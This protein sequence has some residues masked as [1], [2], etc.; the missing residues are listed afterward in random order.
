M[1]SLF[2]VLQDRT[3]QIKKPRH[4]K[5]AMVDEIIKI[6]GVSAKYGYTY[7][8]RKIKDWSY[9]ELMGLLK[10]IEKMDSKYP[11]GATLTNKLLRK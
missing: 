8:L 4:E 11:K 5:S 6:V 7:W 1:Q 9:P 2:D 3:E 10:S